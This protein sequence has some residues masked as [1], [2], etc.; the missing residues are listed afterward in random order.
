MNAKAYHALAATVL[1]GQTFIVD[2]RSR[3]RAD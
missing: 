2:N 3:K 1:L